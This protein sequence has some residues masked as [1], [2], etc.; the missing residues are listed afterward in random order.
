M[1][2]MRIEYE[3][4]HKEQAEKHSAPAQVII[5]GPADEIEAFVTNEHMEAAFP[6]VKP[7]T[8]ADI[9]EE[10]RSGKLVYLCATEEVDGCVK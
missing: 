2:R 8:Q 1:L 4:I 7:L 3:T 9:D 5:T 10:N 6:Y